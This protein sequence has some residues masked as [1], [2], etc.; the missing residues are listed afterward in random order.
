MSC[1]LLGVLVHCPCAQRGM[2]MLYLIIAS[3]ISLVAL[4]LA[5]VAELRRRLPRRT[6]VAR[7]SC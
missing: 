2:R 5:G 1:L 7:D 6:K 3:A 4:V